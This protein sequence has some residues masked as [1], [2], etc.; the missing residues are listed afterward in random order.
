MVNDQKTNSVDILVTGS[1]GFIGRHLCQRLRTSGKTFLGIDLA[2]GYDLTDNQICHT[3]PEFKVAVHLAARTFVPDSWKNPYSFFH[4]NINTT[5]NILEACRIRKASLVLTSSYVYGVPNTLPIS[6][7]HPLSALNPYAHSKLSAESLCK[8]FA[9]AADIPLMIFRPF[10]VFGPGQDERFLIPSILRQWKSG[11]VLL[12]DSKPRRDYLY[13]ADI[14][15]AYFKSLIIPFKGT[16]VIN[17]GSG[18]SYSVKD[19]TES[20]SRLMPEQAIVEFTGEIRKNEIAETRAEI[21]RAM[22][23]LE[24][25]PEHDLEQGLKKTI[26]K[27]EERIQE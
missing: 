22:D 16:E 5:L 17:L 26:E 20:I 19:I 18:N 15:E 21:S 23:L 7:D 2:N 6:E 12:K 10:N 14:V 9:Q 27:H 24:W 8:G 11:K 3:L 4:T 13:V 1:E 25:A